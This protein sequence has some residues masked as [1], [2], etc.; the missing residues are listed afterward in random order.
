MRRCCVDGVASSSPPVS[1]CCCCWWWRWC[2][3]VDASSSSLVESRHR[4]PP[5][6]SRMTTRP[7]TSSWRMIR[8]VAGASSSAR[9]LF[10]QRYAFC[11]RGVPGGVRFFLH[12]CCCMCYSCADADA[13][14]VIL[15][16]WCGAGLLAL[17]A[18]AA[19]YLLVIKSRFLWCKK[20]SNFYYRVWWGA[21]FVKFCWCASCVHCQTHTAQIALNCNAS[22]LHIPRAVKIRRQF[23]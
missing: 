13:D 16:I 20:R 14:I 21:C 4:W 7:P 12:H 3:D 2:D 6:W 9:A 22:M 8:R 15:R 18:D 10:E 23:F 5:S 1:A 19:E 11:F 17:C